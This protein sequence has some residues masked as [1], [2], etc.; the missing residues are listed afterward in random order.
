MLAKNEILARMLY[1]HVQAHYWL[2]Q[3]YRAE[4]ETNTSLTPARH[5]SDF[6]GGKRLQRVFRN[7]VP[8]AREELS[9]A[10]T[11][12]PAL[13]DETQGLVDC[14]YGTFMN[15]W[16][17]QEPIGGEWPAKAS[18][19]LVEAFNNGKPCL[20]YEPKIEGGLI[21]QVSRLHS[22]RPMFTSL[23][24]FKGCPRSSSPT[25]LCDLNEI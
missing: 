25:P 4:C 14:M 11:G 16:F 6:L 1:G 7:V 13:T 21:R 3:K 18:P 24:R 19:Q 15:L 17:P 23:R 10:N 8:K 9:I 2:M 22:T 12:S 20:F 5:R